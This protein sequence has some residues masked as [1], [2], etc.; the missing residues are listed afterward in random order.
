M[1]DPVY[2]AAYRGYIEELLK[3]VLEPSAVT[4]RRQA[5]FARIAPYVA[6]PEGEQP[7]RSFIQSPGEFT[8]AVSS[9]MT[10]VQGRSASVRQALG[11][12]R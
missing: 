1:D 4:A 10:Y 11:N 12:A 8:Q 9:L 6:G 3:T 7:E 2:R 5:E